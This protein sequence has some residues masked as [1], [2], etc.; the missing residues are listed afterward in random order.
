MKVTV[1]Y[2]GAP[3]NFAIRRESP[4]IYYADLMLYEG[5][6]KKSPPEQIMLMR[7]VRYWAGSHDDKLLLSELGE[8]I[9]AI[10]SSAAHTRA[11]N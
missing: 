10:M 1:L 5:D 11:E 4:G 6:Q 7:G 8:K 9:E 3:A 2:K